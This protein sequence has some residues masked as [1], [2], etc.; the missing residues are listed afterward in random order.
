MCFEEEIKS[1]CKYCKDFL[2]VKE[3]DSKKKLSIK[4]KSHRKVCKY[5]SLP[6][7]R[8]LKCTKKLGRFHPREKVAV[9]ESV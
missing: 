3:R 8:L 9:G 7:A 4:R 6:L 1:C 2:L 5:D